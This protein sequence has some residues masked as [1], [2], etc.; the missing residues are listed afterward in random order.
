MSNNL[1]A[2]FLLAVRHTNLSAH[3]HAD[4]E[5][6][7]YRDRVIYLSWYVRRFPT[8]RL[9][10]ICASPVALKPTAV[11][12]IAQGSSCTSASSLPSLGYCLYK[13]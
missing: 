7:D 8:T 11:W 13:L 10:R 12:F 3:S 2:M 1:N 6:R 5:A 9:E 4:T